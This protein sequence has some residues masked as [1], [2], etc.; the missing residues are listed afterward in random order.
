MEGLRG[1]GGVKDGGMAEHKE[2]PGRQDGPLGLNA[3]T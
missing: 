1:C 3:E 2:R